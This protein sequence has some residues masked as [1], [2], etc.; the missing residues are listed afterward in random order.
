MPLSVLAPWAAD[1]CRS[2]LRP[3]GFLELV[4]FRS[5]SQLLSDALG[6]ALVSHSPFH[7]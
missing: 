5:P 4:T 1:T 3:W 6:E 2:I 7:L